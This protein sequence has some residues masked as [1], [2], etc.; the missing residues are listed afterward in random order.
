MPPTPLR[1][2]Q[3]S[4]SLLLGATLALFAWKASANAADPPIAQSDLTT[5][6]RAAADMW[7]G[8]TAYEVKDVHFEDGVCS[9]HLTEGMA[10]PVYTGHP[11]V[12]ERTVGF[13]FTGSGKLQ[14]NFP[15]R[16]DAWEFAN[17]MT[18]RAGED[19]AALEGV[20]AREAPY[21]VAIDRGLLLS[22]DPA[23]EG[24]LN[25]L[26]PIGSGV[27][28][29]KTTE[30]FDEEYVV[31]ES[32][33]A[34]KVKVLGSNLLPERRRL[35]VRGG[36]D[37][38]AML[39]Q[40][41]LLQEAFGFQ[42]QYLRSVM[43]FRTADRYGVAQLTGATIGQ[44]NYDRWMTCFRDGLDQADTGFRSM[45]FSHGLDT[46]GKRHFKRFSGETLPVPE[47]E[48]VPTPAARW[49]PVDADTTVGARPVRMGN[50]I[51][52]EV[53]SILELRA[54]GSTQQQLALALPSWGSA[55][56]TWK[57]QTLELE[58]GSPISWVGLY[59]DMADSRK[60]GRDAADGS[61]LNG[62]EGGVTVSASDDSEVLDAA[63][64]ESSAASA[65]AS[66]DAG[67]GV[68][69]EPSL[70]G[71]TD[72]RYADALATE[73]PVR[74]EV[75]AV[76]PRAVPVGETVRVR[77]KWTGQWQF[78]HWSNLWAGDSY[79]GS[80]LGSTTGLQPLLPELIPAPGGSAWSHTTRVGFP[81][82]TLRSY[83]VALSGT[84]VREWE[85]S[86]QWLWVEAR[87]E[88]EH[89][90][91]IA[92]G[93]WMDFD[94]AASEGMPAVRV[95]LF[96]AQAQHLRE[97]GPEV[98][99]VVAFLERF[100]PDY[101]QG[102]V[103]II[104]GVS[105]FAWQVLAR[106]TESNAAG[107]VNVTT[108]RS[109]QVGETTDV[110]KEDPYLAQTQIARAVAHQYWGQRV[111]AGSDRDRWLTDALADA[112]AAFYV[113][114]AFGPEAYD[115]RMAAIRELLEDPRERPGTWKRAEVTRRSLS[116]TGSTDLSDLPG[117]FL[118]NYGLYVMAH[119]LRSRIGDDAYFLALDRVAQRKGG[120][121][122]TTEQLQ[123][124][125]EETSEQDL[126]DFFDSWVHM[127]RI[128]AL[129][130]EYR[131]ETDGEGLIVQGC[132]ISDVPFGRYE[133]PVQVTDRGGERAAAALVFVEDGL[134]AF[135]VPAREGAIYLE[136]DPD[137]QLLAY[138]RS[139][140]P[141]DRTA[142]DA[143]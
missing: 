132:V 9:F 75:L 103:E 40:D 107:L 58:D 117:H 100:L 4:R 39:R 129:R 53:E 24:L 19:P 131:L 97:F 140:T 52:A 91:R 77:L 69:T 49:E 136:V 101:P 51:S 73:T 12:S 130:V 14:V 118:D 57:L 8:E 41:R 45:A 79:A 137:N 47:G 102:E 54:V 27:V 99:R 31:N 105:A 50:Y 123:A 116:L 125:F 82:T 122:V 1:F 106:G 21:E 84:T 119:M 134:G 68:V 72:A 65:S 13:V 127:A 17:H 38:V 28:R 55:R 81:G 86:A 25:G 78:A 56:G 74:Q 98:R 88:G 36:L 94:E 110:Q 16:A 135:T 124:T 6:W 139:V 61:A 113:R 128:P 143:N 3:R 15:A 104:Q 64:A 22:A 112:Y 138:D 43:D 95:H 32:R 121:R 29:T 63:D 96:S 111:A 109:T 59:E 66:L 93:R 48:L 33:G 120:G 60:T 20:A 23:V 11:P 10:I 26:Q 89:S 44:M 62:D 35:L 115:D 142:C 71:S 30:G 76:L 70:A 114:A 92:I 34:L 90:P 7:M 42:G 133:V 2:A 67:E 37:P 5:W 83:G 108:V 46:E 87:G 18:T 85:D 126:A 80:S 141:V